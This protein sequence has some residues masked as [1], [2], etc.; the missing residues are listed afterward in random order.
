MTRSFPLANRR[1]LHESLGFT[2][3]E[4]MI[5]VVVVAILAAVAFPSF[6]DSIRKSRRSDA[7]TALSQLQL[8]QE[9][10]RANN[11]AFSSN[12]TASPTAVSPA[13]R[14]LGLSTTSANG[15]YTVAIA[16]ADA[17]SYEATATAVSGKSQAQDGSCAKLGVKVSN[18]NIEYAANTVGGALTYGPSNG[19]WGR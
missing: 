3:I 6:M 8:A 12:L 19:C 10:F 16:V 15:Y 13:P 1:R 11:S 5:T 14:G 18:G 2:L 9:R 4:L 17:T 7:M